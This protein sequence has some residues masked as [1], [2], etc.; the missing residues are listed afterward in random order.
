VTASDET[1]PKIEIVTPVKFN[2]V[3]SFY[4]TVAGE[5]IADSN[6]NK[7]NASKLQKFA[8]KSN[9]A[10][11]TLDNSLLG[12]TEGMTITLMMFA[13]KV[14]SYS[15]KYNQEITI[16]ASTTYPLARPPG[17]IAPLHVMAMVSRDGVRLLPPETEYYDVTQNEQ[18]FSIGENIPYITRTLSNA[19]IE[20]YLNG[21]ILTAIRDYTFNNTTN[22]VTMISGVAQTGDVVAITVLKNA[23]YTIQNS[24]ITFNSSA[25]L[26]AGQK[27]I[28]TTYTN[29]DTNLMR[30]EIF[31][32][33]LKNEF[34]LSR[35]VFNINDIW[36]DLN[37]QP[38]TP[39]FDFR[40]SPDGYYV[41]IS[42][43]FTVRTPVWQPLHVYTVSSGVDPIYVRY[44]NKIYVCN[45]SHLSGG[46][47]DLTK[48][49]E[50]P[51]DTPGANSWIPKDDRI[52]VT[53]ISDIISTD[54]IAYRIFKDMSNKQQYKRIS[55]HDSTI[56]T[57]ELTI[58]DLEISNYTNLYITKFIH[59][60]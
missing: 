31:E 22:T 24:S 2:D 21:K 6:I 43:R 41:N 38:L 60:D 13:S 56:L 45:E 35:P 5:V 27:I 20:V 54:S 7:F 17:N 15:E 52:V 28:V 51:Y 12:I 49:Q 55:D 8:G 14:K 10:K 59:N 57:T 9:R 19:D 26:Q 53:S 47:I 33:N 29:H 16:D 32:G 44:N 36:V 34:K 4:V 40:L 46:Q 39:N 23:N 25:S 3:G 11:V 30:R 50:V 58:T 48:F 1:S 37:G 42:K 18:V